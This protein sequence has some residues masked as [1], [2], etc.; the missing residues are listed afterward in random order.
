MFKKVHLLFA[1]ILGNALEFYNFVIYGAFAVTIARLYFPDIDPKISLFASLGTFASGFLMR[2][3]GGAF[4]G[5]IGDRLGRKKALSLSIILMGI[6]SFIIG[7]LPT[8]AEI[9]MLAPLLMIGCRLIQGLSAGG[10]YNGA[11]IFALEHVGKK[12]PGFTGGLISASCVMGA[13]AGTVLAKLIIQFGTSSMLWRLPFIL[14]G[15]VC[16]L[17][18]YIRR[19]IEESPAFN[20]AKKRTKEQNTTNQKFPLISVFKNR[21]KAMLATICIGA[22]DGILCYTLFGFLNIYLSIYIGMELELAL[23]SSIY[24]LFSCMLASPLMGYILDKI[25]GSNFFQIVCPIVALAV[26]PIFNLIQ[27]QDFYTVVVAQIL[28]GIAT[29]SI[30]GAF[31]AYVQT[32]F[33]VQERYSGISFSFNIGSALFGGTAPLI[34][35]YLITKTSNLYVPAIYISFWM[36]LCFS[37][38]RYLIGKKR[39][40]Y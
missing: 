22:S 25:G 10:E 7:I 38:V 28:F 12:F 9:G 8:Y 24:G 5:Y 4:F 2:P 36:F 37:S 30:S 19:N 11:A 6:P 35:A 32:L 31:H 40:K 14:G 21:K 27:S 20:E 29:A 17:G 13:I 16:L 3:F 1:C 18:V 33:P 15:F 23:E 39:V 34:L 26:Y